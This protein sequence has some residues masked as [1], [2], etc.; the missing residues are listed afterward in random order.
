MPS[1]RLRNRLDLSFCPRLAVTAF[2][3]PELVFARRVAFCPDRQNSRWSVNPQRRQTRDALITF[4]THRV[5]EESISQ[6]KERTQINSLATSK[7]CVVCSNSL[8]TGI[9]DRTYGGM[10]LIRLLQ[11][12]PRIPLRPNYFVGK[13]MEDWQT[14]C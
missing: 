9:T 4:S 1:P 8:E 6:K 13:T 3:L 2:A 7:H 14:V 5:T 11:T 10:A 12:L